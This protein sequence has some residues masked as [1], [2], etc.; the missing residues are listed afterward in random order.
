MSPRVP[1]RGAK[2][3]P[4]AKKAPAAKPEPAAPDEG[5]SSV[6]RDGIAF[7]FLAIAVLPRV[8]KAH[9]ARSGGVV[10]PSAPINE[11][12]VVQAHA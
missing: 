4:A 11:K 9:V 2:K 8:F 6:R 3:K 7:A 5:A 12:G 1:Q 10:P